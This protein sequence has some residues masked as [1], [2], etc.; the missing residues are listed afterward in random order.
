M[1]LTIVIMIIFDVVHPLVVDSHRVS[2]S[3]LD[4][5]KNDDE[6]NVV[7]FGLPAGI[8]AMLI[9]LQRIALWILARLCTKRRA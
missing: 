5:E 7:L 4:D 9:V 3:V 2:P 1:V 8:I 6:K